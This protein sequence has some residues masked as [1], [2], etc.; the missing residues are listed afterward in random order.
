MSRGR[1]FTKNTSV[2]N[3]PVF[4]GPDFDFNEAEFDS[5]MKNRVY[6]VL[7]ICSNYDYFMLEEDGRIDEQIF[8]E[9]VSLSL[10]Y[11]PIFIHAD[12][13]RKAFDILDRENIDL[14]ITM[15]SVGEMDAFGLSR[16]VKKEYPTIPIV[17]LTPFSREVSMKLVKEDLSA[18]DYVFSWLGNADLLLAIIKLIEDKMN[19]AYDVDEVGVQTILLIEDSVRY[20]S[21]YLPDIYKIVFTQSKSFM[22]EGLNEHKKMLRMR[23]RP[24]ILLATNYEDAEILYKRYRENMLGIISDVSFKR[25][26]VKEMD[27]GIQFCRMVR[28]EN[29]FMPLLIQS[30]NLGNQAKAIELKASFL[31]KYSKT[32]EIELRNFMKRYMAFG[33]FIFRHPETGEEVGRAS[34]L[35]EMQEVIL[36]I[37]PDCLKSHF[38]NNDIS[39]W[40]NA[41]AFF[42]IAR[43]LKHKTL[44]DFE[45]IDDARQHIYRLI[46][47]YRLAKARGVISKFDRAR[48]D[49]YML[50][51][52][53][54]DGSLGGKARGLAFIDSFIKRN[55]LFKKWDKVL[56]TIPRTVVISTE[57][58]EEF[59]DQ[60][61]LWRVAGTKLNDEQILNLFVNATL[62]VRIKE[63]LVAFSKVARGPIAIRSSSLL[64]DSH[65]QPF[66]GIYSTF[67]IPKTESD[68]RRMIEML[69]DS[70]K[71]VYASVYFKSPRAYM[72]ATQNL[73]DSERM[74]IILQEVCG[75][76]YGNKY[77]P[78]ISGV[79][80]SIN[81]YPIGQEKREDGIAKIA[82]GL[83]KMIV[84]GGISLRFS[85]RFPKNVLQVSSPEAAL[86]ETQKEFYALDLVTDHFHPST[87]DGVNLIK[88]KLR[89]AENESALRFVA[90]TYD[91]E[92]N[93]IRDNYRSK[94]RKVLTFNNILKHE[95]FPLAEIIATL[96]KIGEQE[97]NNPIEI[98]FAVNLDVPPGQYPIFNFLQIRP[99]V[100][101]TDELSINLDEVDK[102]DA[103]IFSDSA[104]GNGFLKGIHDFV[105]VKPESFRAADS[106]AI[107]ASIEKINDKF[108]EIARNYILVG[109]GRWGSSD[110][111]LGIPVKW[112]QIS[113]ARLIVESG[114]K[115]Y[116]IDPSQGT[117]FFQNLTSFRVGYFTINPYLNEGIF[118]LDYLS[119]QEAV[120]EDKHIRHVLFKKPVMIVIDGRNSKG[121]VYKEGRGELNSTFNSS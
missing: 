68:P 103:I 31:H 121:V 87:D 22:Q 53:I 47:M 40:L 44:D 9:Y 107:A 38:N 13:A 65:Y 62:P 66:A 10:R 105:Y 89:E 39:K 114:L 14:V 79:A 91:F 36:K 6:R 16:R 81:F 94:G 88:I 37:P 12:S 7:I 11:P 77:Y 41:R 120:F 92:H 8:N 102:S 60:N 32:L 72:E 2:E 85:P 20:Y 25:N 82:F 21:S 55:R 96:L 67:M 93:V 115:D 23:G 98:E 51:S 15:L 34:N 30:S 75:T 71:S 17:V 33:V 43:H 116:R 109:P 95:S 110:P 42:Q 113:A 78:T 52:R 28:E 101:S 99:I 27:A 56:V 106:R 104:L 26:G 80:R 69:S 76:R 119:S 84:E 73:I 45:N 1:I 108:V 18:I 50:F 19:L 83:G 61:N 46:S 3:I 63:D 97:M 64:E 58:F 90:S 100:Q 24:K 4:K 29:P 5:L 112:S 49:E 117:H 111:W 35:K 57:I 59:M 86:K 118:D 48:F 54:G 74:A 70:V